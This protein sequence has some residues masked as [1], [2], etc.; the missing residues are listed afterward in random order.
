MALPYGY[1]LLAWGW[2][3]AVRFQG[4]FVTL[5]QGW[6]VAFVLPSTAV[7]WLLICRATDVLWINTVVQ[8]VLIAAIASLLNGL[9]RWRDG[10]V[11]GFMPPT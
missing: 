3:I 7:W 8:I 10:R 2:A 11:S 6:L 4:L 1:A 9:Q 5:G